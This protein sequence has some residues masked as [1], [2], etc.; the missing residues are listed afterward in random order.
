MKHS[1]ALG[2][3]IALTANSAFADGGRLIVTDAFD[4]SANW[5]MYANE[6]YIGARA[7]CY[8]GL[9]YITKELRVEPLLATSW[10]QTDPNTWVF[11]LREGV[12]FQDGTA[13][14]G[15]AVAGALTHLLN[16]PV[17]ARAF[18]KKVATGV[19]ATGPLEVTITTPSPQVSMPGRLGAPDTT[20]LSPAAYVGADEINP[21][22]NCTGP[23]EI[24]EVDAK[25]F[26]K[27]G[28]FVRAR[29]QH[30]RDYGANWRSACVTSDP[31]CFSG[32]DRI[33]RRRFY[34]RGAGPARF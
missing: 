22:G 24:V 32:T 31:C 2:L 30:P 8:E 21:M 7:G 1:V 26:V 28:H 33:A 4:I 3:A 19:E 34:G 12:M 23:F 29:W 18:S 20:I 15:E 14:T 17:P 25:Q 16:A 11:Q 13:L 9:T 6:A 27:V 10:E 5:A